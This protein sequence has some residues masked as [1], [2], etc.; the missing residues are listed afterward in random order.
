MNTLTTT[1]KSKTTGW[2]C[3]IDAYEPSLR[4][5]K[6]ACEAFVADMERGASP[7][8]LTLLGANGCGKTM[9]LR[10]VFQEAKRINPGNP[11]HNPIWPPNWAT[12]EPKVNFYTDARPYCLWYDE[13]GMA[14]RMRS[15]DYELP[16]NCRT[17]FF[18]GLDE[19]GITRDPTNFISEAVGTLCENRLNRW[20][21]FASNLSLPQIS[22]RMDARITSRMV[23][24]ENRLVTIQAGDYA[25]RS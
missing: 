6:A 20:T 10:Q 9:M 25:L 11:A 17:D 12:F 8:W 15:G 4:A 16:R 21:V 13:G 18:V 5:A 14:S 19:V 23:R 7:Y 2:K 3:R 22:E 24:D 1:P